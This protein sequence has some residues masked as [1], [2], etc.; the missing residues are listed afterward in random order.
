MNDAGNS[1][2]RVILMASDGT[3]VEFRAQA[4]RSL[5]KAAAVAGLRLTSG[6]LQGRCTICRAHLLRGSV[7]PVRSPSPNGVGP[8]PVRDD[9]TVLLCSVG[10][11][12]DI[13]IAP[14]SPW[15]ACAPP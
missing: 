14:L 6:C 12:S 5:I 4:G 11:T 3:R 9:G 1:G 7:M 13:E 8:G 2:H 15:R 10:A